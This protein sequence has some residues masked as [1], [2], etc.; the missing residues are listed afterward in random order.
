MNTSGIVAKFKKERKKLLRD[1]AK[2]DGVLTALGHSALGA[3]EKQRR[4]YSHNRAARAAISRAQKAR[5]KK[6]KAA[7]S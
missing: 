2:I 5:W 4:K 3:Y 6:I 1:L 7:K